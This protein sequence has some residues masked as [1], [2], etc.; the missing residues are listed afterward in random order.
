MSESADTALFANT[1]SAEMTAAFQVQKQAF[2]EQMNPDYATRIHHLTE[3]RA[4]LVKHQTA[5][6]EAVN[7]DFGVR[8]STETLLAE[9]APSLQSIDYTCKH[10]KHWMSA[11]RRKVQIQYQPAIAQVYYQPLGVVG[12]IVPFNYPIFL[13]LS[14]LITALAAGNRVMLKMSEFTPHT[15]K[16]IKTLLGEVFN[17]D[18]V[19]VI[20]GEADIAA[21]FCNLPFDH[22]FFTGSTTVGKHVM[23][24]A[25]QNL[26]PVTLELGGK[27]PVIV[28]DDCSIKEAVK[29]ICYAKSLNAG[30]TCV[31]P[32]YI[33]IHK[34]RKAAF[35]KHYLLAFNEMYPDCVNNADYSAIINEAHY[36]R[37]QRL[38]SDAEEK[39]A[40]LHKPDNNSQ[41]NDTLR[42]M[43]IT[44]I[45]A[46]TDEMLVLQEELF[47][48]LLPIIEIENLQEAIDYIQQR[49]RPLALYYFS[50]HLD[51]QQRVL[52]HTHS[53]GVGINECLLH[54]AIDDLPFG[55]IGASGMGQYHAYEGF[56][57]F[58]KAKSVLSKG[59]LSSIKMI[60]P[61]YDRWWK[62]MIL[63]W[64]V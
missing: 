52:E 35:I 25:A 41:A 20:I 59:T 10:L 7:Q 3:L 19:T 9:I 5:I 40:T 6:T 32:D 51:R 2:Q 4:A 29:R 30:Q 44:L 22:L 46:A 57:T 27:S 33:F 63:R 47:G 54:V 18:L 55:G 42:K 45:E 8:S 15:A 34:E 28:D 39:G 13:A 37:L 48:P 1:T 11:E 31:A 43:P 61:P 36:Q 58:S 23:T 49:P 21:A 38:L 14:P 62:K 60:Y 64:L 12:I 16:L 56:L 53:G 26:T 17:E 24:A 50:F